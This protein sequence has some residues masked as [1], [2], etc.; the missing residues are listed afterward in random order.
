MAGIKRVIC[1]LLAWLFAGSTWGATSVLVNS[2]SGG[3]ISPLIDVRM[4]LTK[5]S[6]SC[7]TMENVIPLVQGPAVRRPGTKYV[8]FTKN[9]GVARLVSWYYAAGDSYCLE[10]GD[11]YVRFF[12]SHG[13]VLDSNSDPYEVNTPY[14]A[15]ELD[16]I[17]W[18]QSADVMYLTHPLHRPQKLT[19]S[20][21]ASWTCADVNIID[22]PFLT[23]N[24]TEVNIVPSGTTGAISLTASGSVFDGNQ[25]GALWRLRQVVG[26]SDANDTFTAIGDGNEVTIADDQGWEAVLSGTW[27]GEVQ[28][29]YSLD[30]NLWL[31]YSTMTANER[32]IGEN[33]YDQS[34]YFRV[35]CTSYTSGTVTWHLYSQPYM[36]IGIVR[37]SDYNEPNVVQADVLVGL[38]DANAT[39]YWSEGAWSDLRGY[40]E[41]I[42]TYADRVLYA[43]TSHQPTRMWFSATG[44]YEQFRAG[45]AADDSFAYTLSVG[46]QH[47]IRWIAIP[48]RRGMIVGTAGN[49][50]EI[51]PL[52]TTAAIRPDNPPVIGS[53]VSIPCATVSAIDADNALLYIQRGGRKVREVIYDYDSDSIASPD[54]TLLSDHITAG[55]IT[56]LAWQSRPY[57][58]LWTTRSDGVVVTNTYDRVN[59]MAAWGRQI[60]DGDVES[61][62]VIPE[63]EED[64]VWWI[65]H[66]DIDGNDV[67]YVEYLAPWSWGD[68]QNDV[69]FVDCGLSWSGGDPANITGISKASPGVVTLSTW[70]T[71]GSG[72][73]LADGNQILIEGVL[74][75][76][77]INGRVFTVDDAN[78]TAK[79][80]S[81]DNSAGGTN[82]TTAG[83]STYTSG[84]TV[85]CVEKDFAGATHLAGMAV[86]VLA[87][88]AVVEGETIS[89][90]GTLNLSDF[91]TDV[92][93]GL[94]YDSTIKTVRFDMV[95][96]RGNTRSRVKQIKECTASLYQTWGISMGPDAGHMKRINFR[97][98]WDPIDVNP[99]FTGDKT[100]SFESTMS[101]DISVTIRQ[102]QPLPMTV[103]AL[104]PYVE[105][106]D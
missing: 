40:P 19:R 74:G 5:Y 6:S 66:R 99:L 97:N 62:A 60:T 27:V 79:T 90:T 98:S 2:F 30:G 52:D 41:T 39:T 82:F 42:S 80:F 76:T 43:C 23:E 37:I 94:G 11:R 68:D 92:S 86:E 45:T 44:D 18:V 104:V 1:F 84:G 53:R 63:D 56:G 17:Q 70:P 71:L 57:P 25:V 87:Q 20:D 81:L 65:A 4:D 64:E 47:P 106:Y 89:G 101:Q 26:Q 50:L 67:R 95:S 7:Q 105:V 21:H 59:S 78:S 15:T 29:Q 8:A 14:L 33:T 96:D 51:Q 34:V 75:M 28:V 61:I 38:A 100:L 46:Q 32:V 91:V 93:M 88:G 24:D 69:F 10:F 49:V 58:I 22:G 55:G 9:N 73:A 13:Q 3:E 12:R 48:E 16:R 77:Q 35:S 103:R 31:T 72:A 54:I 102:D 83:Y 85:R 36:H